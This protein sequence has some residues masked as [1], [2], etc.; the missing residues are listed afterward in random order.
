MWLS[1]PR[2]FNAVDDEDLDGA[3]LTA[4]GRSW[5]EKPKEFV[6]ESAQ[7]QQCED[8]TESYIARHYRKLSSFAWRAVNAASVH[9]IG[10]LRS[11]A[12]ELKN[13]SSNERTSF[14]RIVGQSKTP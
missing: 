11:R 13:H 1:C 8:E 4:V 3:F 5:P 7:C 6:N 9:R 12:K 14:L 10:Y 2:L